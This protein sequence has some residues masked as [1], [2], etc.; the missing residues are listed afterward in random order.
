[1]SRSNT[2]KIKLGNI[3]IGG[4]SKITVQSMTNTDTRD[5]AATIKQIKSLEKMGCDIVRCAVPDIEACT[6]LKDITKSVNIPVVA[7]IHFDY[8]LAI[9]SIENG[10]FAL[11]INPGNIG[12]N[13]RV[14]EVAKAAQNSNIPIRIGVN[15]GSLN[16]DMLKKYGGVSSDALVESALNHVKIL[17]NVNFDNIVISIKSSNVIQMVDSYR[18]I[19]RIC[20]YPLHLGVTEAGT[21]FTG[22]IKS[23]VGIGTLLMEGIGDTIRVSLTGDPIQEVKVGKEILKACGLR[24]QGIEL[25]SCPTCGRT[26]INIIKIA[27]EVERRLSHINKNIRVA[28]MG[29]VVNGPGEA[30]EADIGIAGGKGEG[31]IFK[32]GNII[33]KVREENLV[34]A[35]MEEIQNM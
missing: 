26:E 22:T 25:I 31:L 19:S 2:K 20:Q 4:D 29:C 32:N 33:K 13:D 18:K 11:R 27:E 8:R 16:K 34:E 17:E 14:K 3:F 12:S 23:S 1:M 28:V 21:G 35:L 10:V 7:D 5:R 9:K 30:R 6:A 15:S 24:K